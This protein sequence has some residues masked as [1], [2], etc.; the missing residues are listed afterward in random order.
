MYKNNGYNPFDEIM[1][2]QITNYPTAGNYGKD[3][4]NTCW[5][6]AAGAG[7]EDWLEA[8]AAS[9]SLADQTLKLANINLATTKP[10]STTL[11]VIISIAALTTIGTIAFIAIKHKGVYKQA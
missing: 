7:D 4:C 3:G 5:R 11:K 9:P 1:K 6:N 2:D 10:M 8:D